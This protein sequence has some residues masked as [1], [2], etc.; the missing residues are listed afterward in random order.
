MQRWAGSIMHLVRS[1]FPSDS[2]VLVLIKYQPNETMIGNSV[3]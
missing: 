1:A 3:L 2:W